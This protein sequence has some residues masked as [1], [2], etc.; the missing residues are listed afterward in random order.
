MIELRPNKPKI[1]NLDGLSELVDFIIG[2]SNTILV[3]FETDS[4]YMSVKNFFPNVDVDGSEDEGGEYIELNFD[5]IDVFFTFLAVYKDLDEVQQFIKEL[6]ES[7]LTRCAQLLHA[8][9]AHLG[10]MGK[11][12]Y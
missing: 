2:D 9:N 3:T 10:T 8:Y 11:D 5:D 7:L 12:Y 4:S 6:N 1:N